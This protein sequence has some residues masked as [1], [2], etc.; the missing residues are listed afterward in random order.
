[1]VSERFVQRAMRVMSVSSMPSASRTTATG[2]PP[3]GAEEKTSTW[4]NGR[5]RGMRPLSTCRRR[6]AAPVASPGSRSRGRTVDAMR[7][8]P[9]GR[10]G[11]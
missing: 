3:Y 1:V 11:E 8:P 7:R 6:A 2:L 5:V 9:S 10:M 4:A